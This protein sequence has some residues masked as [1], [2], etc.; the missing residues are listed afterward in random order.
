LLQYLC[1]AFLEPGG[2]AL[3][4]DPGYPREHLA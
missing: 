1:V 3:A 2:V 4:S